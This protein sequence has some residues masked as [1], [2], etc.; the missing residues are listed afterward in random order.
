MKHWGAFSE[1][2]LSA[3]GTAEFVAKNAGCENLRNKKFGSPPWTQFE[4]L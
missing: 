2:G 1:S 4:L 3:G